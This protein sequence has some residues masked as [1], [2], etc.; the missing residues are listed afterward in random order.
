MKAFHK[1]KS[2]E[3]N[4][5]VRICTRGDFLLVL[6]DQQ[7]SETGLLTHV[8]D[9][10][11]EVGGFE[12][13]VLALKTP[14]RHHVHL[15]HR[16]RVRVRS[17][18]LAGHFGGVENSFGVILH[19]LRVESLVVVG[20]EVLFE[21][22]LPLGGVVARPAHERFFARVHP[23][24]SAQLC[25]TV[26]HEVA[27]VARMRVVAFTRCVDHHL[28][29]FQLNGRFIRV[30]RWL[31]MELENIRV[32]IFT[33]KSRQKRVFV[34]FGLHELRR[35]ALIKLRY[36]VLVFELFVKLLNYFALS[37]LIFRMFFVASASLEVL[38]HV[39]LPLRSVRNSKK[40]LKI[41]F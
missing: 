4:F 12:R 35:S 1:A 38:H 14:V 26:S 2:F 25:R 23:H 17:V 6:L 39:P 5:L 33:F 18:I 20:F 40:T 31:G 24:V 37:L 19:Q 3:K 11:G 32:R 22:T 8:L 28:R 30:A 10:P 29:P 9:Q 16:L 41:T 13:A 36:S 21:V 15:T 27:L 34:E 7:A